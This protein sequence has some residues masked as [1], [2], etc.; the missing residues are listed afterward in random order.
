MS[1]VQNK[2]ELYLL[3]LFIVVRNS[4]VL[5][6]GLELGKSKEEINKM[7]YETINEL[8]IMI[9]FDKAKEMFEEGQRASQKGENNE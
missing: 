8:M 1:K 9:D 4:M 2:E 7:T 5:P 6:K 3:T